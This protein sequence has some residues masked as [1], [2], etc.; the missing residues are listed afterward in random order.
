MPAV[1]LGGEKG[2]KWET[3]TKEEGKRERER[4]GERE[5]GCG[6]RRRQKQ[7]LIYW[8]GKEWSRKSVFIVKLIEQTMNRFFFQLPHSSVFICLYNQ[9]P[10]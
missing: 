2:E 6:A 4:K 10:Q 1:S 7:F 9:Q 5:R 8:K 3:S